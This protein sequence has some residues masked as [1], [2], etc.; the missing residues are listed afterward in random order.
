MLNFIKIDTFAL[1]V[2][3]SALLEVLKTSQIDTFALLVGESA[4]MKVLKASLGPLKVTLLTTLSGK[5]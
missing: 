3:G 1:L 2:G 4:L 5:V